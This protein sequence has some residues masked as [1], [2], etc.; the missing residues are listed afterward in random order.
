MQLKV[1]FCIC[2]VLSRLGFLGDNKNN[3]SKIFLLLLYIRSFSCVCVC[4]CVCV[5]LMY[6]IVNV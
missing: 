3:V 2:D 5:C 6:I 1:Y 4:V